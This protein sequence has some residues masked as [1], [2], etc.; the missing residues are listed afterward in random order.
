VTY[1]SRAGVAKGG[2]SRSVVVVGASDVGAV[3]MLSGGAYGAAN[4]PHAVIS[5][6]YQ[7]KTAYPILGGAP[8]RPTAEASLLRGGQH[9]WR[10]PALPRRRGITAAICSINCG[11]KFAIARELLSLPSRQG[12]LWT[13]FQTSEPI[14][15]QIR[16]QNMISGQLGPSRHQGRTGTSPARPQLRAV[17]RSVAMED[18]QHRREA[19]PQG[20]RGGWRA[21]LPTARRADSRRRHASD[22]LPTARRLVRAGAASGCCPLRALAVPQSGDFEVL[23]ASPPAPLVRPFPQRS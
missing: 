12:V 5:P 8:A 13:T 10:G 16:H 17:R 19:A 22:A 11:P 6:R 14:A 21:R 7:A 20:R 3:L 18:A 23:R 9:T 15:V 2:V 4:A 1:S